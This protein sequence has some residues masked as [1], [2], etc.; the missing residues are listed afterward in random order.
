MR[1]QQTRWN[2]TTQSNEVVWVDV[3]ETY[4]EYV[5]VPSDGGGGGYDAGSGCGGGGE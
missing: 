4:V 3:P 2:S 1:K 5:D